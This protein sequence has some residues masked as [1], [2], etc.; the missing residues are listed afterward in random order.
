MSPPTLTTHTSAEG[1]VVQL[2]GQE[3]L[4]PQN[5]LSFT[6]PK[7]GLPR[8]RERERERTDLVRIGD[9]RREGIGALDPRLLAPPPLHT[10]QVRA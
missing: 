10:K 5:A 2:M 1:G 3:S 4:V 6:S 8:E 7:T 9:G